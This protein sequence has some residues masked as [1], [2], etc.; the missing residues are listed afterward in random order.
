MS[1][2]GRWIPSKMLPIIPGPNS[3]DRGL[4]VRKTG[5]PTL[6]PEVSSYTYNNNNNNIKKKIGGG[7]VT[8]KEESESQKTM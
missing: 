5:S 3:T 6:T 8:S 7:K 4:P 2:K 1:S